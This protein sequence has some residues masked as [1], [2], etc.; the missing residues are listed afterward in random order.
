MRPWSNHIVVM[1]EMNSLTWVEVHLLVSDASDT[2]LKHILDFF[3]IVYSFKDILLGKMAF[4][5]HRVNQKFMEPILLV[6][7]TNLITI[8]K[9]SWWPHGLR[10]G[11]AF[12]KFLLVSHAWKPLSTRLLVSVLCCVGTGL[13]EQLITHSRNLYQM[14]ACVWSCVI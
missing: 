11:P 4:F 3:C 13:C 6:H 2:E 14:C 8:S 9:W 7:W 10:H 12:A 5:C 1:E